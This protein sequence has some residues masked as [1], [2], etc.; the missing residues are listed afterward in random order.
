M[1]VREENFLDQFQSCQKT[2]ENSKIGLLEFSPTGE[3]FSYTV[4]DSLKIFSSL[5]F[6]LKNIITARMDTMCYFQNNTLI[7]SRDSTLYYLSV[8]DNKYLGTFRGHSGKVKSIS[9]DS[10]NDRFMSV[11]SENINIWDIRCQNPT[12]SFRNNGNIGA[13]SHDNT[14]ALCSTNFVYLYDIRKSSS[15][16][17]VQTIKPGFY[18][19]IWYTADSSC[20]CLSDFQN[21]LFLDKNGDYLTSLDLENDSDGCTIDDSNIF[22]SGSARN[23]LVY[24]IQDKKRI[25]RLF[26]E[27]FEVSTARS[28]HKGSRIILAS[29][30]S[31]KLFVLCTSD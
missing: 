18:K 28:D 8:Y 29:D 17:E 3:F 22:I 1:E 21:H 26:L 24:K 30:H 10:T 25:G 7:H 31:A 13:I 16:K 6:H 14:F 2:Q 9:V 12:F 19:K 20:L 4:D 27:D 23:V 15:P 11:G 5:D